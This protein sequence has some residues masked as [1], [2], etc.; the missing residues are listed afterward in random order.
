LEQHLTQRNIRNIVQNLETWI[1][2]P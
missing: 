2:V 1:W